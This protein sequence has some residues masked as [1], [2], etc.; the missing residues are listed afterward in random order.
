MKQMQNHFILLGFLKIQPATGYELKKMI[1]E[2]V[3]HFWN[4]SF[5]QIY[6]TLAKM[7]REGLV[8][9]EL[10]PQSGKPDKKIYTITDYG[11][12]LLD[13]WLRSEVHMPKVKLE[14]LVKLFFGFFVSKEDVL[15]QIRL[16][17]KTNMELLEQMNGI[18]REVKQETESDP[19]MIF[20]LFTVKYGQAHYR[21]SVEWCDIV[22]SKLK[23]LKNEGRN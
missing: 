9:S 13:E 18:E 14:I 16:F 10:K 20:P 8:E 17:R 5:S 21:A 6:P 2:S 22:E 19:D 1:D 4:E 23:N 12:G 7:E 3:S 15:R 11:S